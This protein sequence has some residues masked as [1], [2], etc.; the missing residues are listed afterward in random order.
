ML[1]EHEKNGILVPTGDV[2]ALAGAM[3]RL[4]L[5]E[6][7]RKHLGTEASRVSSSYSPDRIKEIWVQLIRAAA[8][9][10]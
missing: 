2:A 3:E 9:S 1:I 6:P 10:L 7:L 5:D 4:I 8:Q